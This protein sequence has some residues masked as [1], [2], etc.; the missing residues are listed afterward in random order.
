M[1]PEPVRS[2]ERPRITGESDVPVASVRSTVAV[3]EA[4]RDVASLLA[5]DDAGDPADRVLALRGLGRVGGPRAL[6]RLRAAL[7]APDPLVVSA[8][9]AGLGV[10]A[11]LDD[12]AGEGAT[13]PLL[14]A[15]ERVSAVRHPAEVIE[16]LGRAGDATALPLLVTLVDAARA[17]PTDASTITAGETA[18]YAL[19]RY[20]RR[21]LPIDAAARTALVAA[22]A[23]P[24]ARMRYAVVYALAREQ[25]GTADVDPAQTVTA[26]AALAT[27]RVP[28]IRA[29][30]AAALGRRGDRASARATLLGLLD[31]GDW[32]VAVEAVRAL[33]GS[34]GGADAS[35]QR[36]V[37]AA[38]L[39]RAA[40]LRESPLAN[41]HV[42]LEALR[43]LQAATDVTVG[44]RVA[45]V[46]AAL[47]DGGGGP[48]S[49][50]DRAWVE[51][52]VASHALRA[53]KRPKP[54]ALGVLDTCGGAA[55][56][57]ASTRA[58][59]IADAIVAGAGT[60]DD[61]RRHAAALV[62]SADVGSQLAAFAP[63]AALAALDPADAATALAAFARALAT[64]D[65]I[66]AGGAVD[67][68]PTLVT[69]LATRLPPATALDAA[70]VERA[71]R[72]L[73]AAD[74]ALGISLLGVIGTRKLGAGLPA[75]RAALA[76]H[77][78][79]ARAGG[80]C[81]RDAGEAMPPLAEPSAAPLPPLDVDALGT[82]DLQWTVVTTRGPLHIRLAAQAAPWAVAAITQ[83]S[84]RHFYDGTV[85]H[86]VVPNFVAQ[87][88][89]PT[90]TGAGGPGFVLPP[91]PASLHDQRLDGG[92]AVGGVGLADGGP[93]TAGSQ[94]FVMHSH[95]PHLDGRYTWFGTLAPDDQAV[96]DALQIGDRI[97]SATV[98]PAPPAAAT[99]RSPSPTLLP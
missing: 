35:G 22:L 7:A 48:D 47:A 49:L 4:R 99:S 37:A 73:A 14:A 75:C 52:L 81:L 67:A 25:R 64:G 32:R 93:G 42:V 72:E 15:Y 8:A 98:E 40:N 11:A 61:R 57:P 74:P 29:T 26:I 84:A 60:L 54:N 36:A 89:D 71:G 27:D 63:L 80:E 79:L 90:G 12:R 51:C 85:F 82:A 1:D 38:L 95:A 6:A 19:A 3:A 55:S 68:L 24:D 53:T 21:K 96:A 50:T 9:A 58:T 43:V 5:L 97:V 2:I 33:G 41:T 77:P 92:F 45:G 30:A 16:A 69:A 59:I 44:R 34:E 62:A 17:K 83:L 13:A 76:L 46:S 23:H 70:V 39:R 28:E 31:D 86:R 10:A 78:A 91:E 20:G 56:L 65:A 88:G 66:L 94:W 18:A 87:G